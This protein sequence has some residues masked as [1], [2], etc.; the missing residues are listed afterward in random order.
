MHAFAI[1]GTDCAFGPPPGARFRLARDG[2][3]EDAGGRAA[4]FLR[5]D[6][7]VEPGT[8]V[9]AHYDAMLAKVI[10]WSPERDGAARRLA[11]A[12]AAARIA[13]PATNRDL[14]VG[15]LRD[16]AFLDGGADTSLLDDYDFSGLL[17]AER[18]CRI[19][20]AAAAA[21][22][23]AAN[24]RDARAA[25]ALPGGWRNVVSQPQLTSFTGPRGLIDVRY[26]WTRAGI[27]IAAVATERA[28]GA[29]DDGGDDDP[30]MTVGGLAPDGV[31]LDVAGVRY[32]FDIT[33]AGAEIW[34]DSPLGSVRLTPLD[35]LP[36]PERAEE[37][38]S[39]VAPMP[40]SVTRIAAAPGDRVLAGQLVLVLE[41]MKMEHQIAAPA[42]GVL[43]EL[44]V[45]Q[46]AQV[47]AGDV[48]AIVTADE[49]TNETGSDDARR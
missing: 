16:P 24:R 45:G 48:L 27:T 10:A 33:R 17:P 35:R 28:A 42:S 23:A 13:G 41:A 31:T 46:G 39:L 18:I 4:P 38:G 32:R 11:A 8:S 2:P 34:V 5:L 15:V 22:V 26:Y 40:G 44:R 20:A 30:S 36:A 29:A 12:L 7:G 19:S 37:S 6:S 14:L 49:A 43:A 3:G 47:N 21:A 1:P 25:A 9:S